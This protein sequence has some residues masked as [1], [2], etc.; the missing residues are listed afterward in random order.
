MSLIDWGGHRLVEEYGI[1]Y[2]GS[3]LAEAW[4]L[5]CHPDGASTIVNGE[6]VTILTILKAILLLIK[7]V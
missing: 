7:L 1:E 3:I 4:E 6:L 5:S 2:E